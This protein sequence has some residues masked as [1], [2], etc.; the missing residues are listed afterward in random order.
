MDFIPL[1]FEDYYL[2]AKRET[3]E[4]SDVGGIISVL[5]SEDFS[6]L[7]RN[8]PGYDASHAGEVTSVSDLIG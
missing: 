2:L 7:V 1:F 4:R 8:N 3:I 5:K 6:G